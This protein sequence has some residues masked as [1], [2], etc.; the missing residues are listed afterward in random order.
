[1]GLSQTV[2]INGGIT[3]SN[4]KQEA[5]TEADN[6]RGRPSI[7]ASRDKQGVLQRVTLNGAYYRE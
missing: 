7:T 1:M 5:M 4:E 2:K 6:K 3:E